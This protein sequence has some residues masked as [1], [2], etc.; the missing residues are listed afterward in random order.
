MTRII[1][2]FI[3]YAG[4]VPCVA[5]LGASEMGA[6]LAVTR[7]LRDNSRLAVRELQTGRIGLPAS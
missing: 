3:N 7:G 2:Q 4:A 6:E 1:F 5:S